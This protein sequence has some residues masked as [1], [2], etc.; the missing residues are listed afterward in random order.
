VRTGITGNMD[1]SRL[2]ERRRPHAVID[3]VEE[4]LGWL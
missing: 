2:P 4:L 3:S 1:V